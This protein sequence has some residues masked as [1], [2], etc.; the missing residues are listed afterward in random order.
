MY[1]HTECIGEFSVASQKNSRCFKKPTSDIRNR[2]YLLPGGLKNALGVLMNACIGRK[3]KIDVGRWKIGVLFDPRK[4]LDSLIHDPDKPEIPLPNARKN[5]TSLH[6]HLFCI[7]FQPSGS[8]YSPHSH[9]KQKNSTPLL[10]PEFTDKQSLPT[11]L[12]YLLICTTVL[13][14]T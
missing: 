11:P 5:H 7:H 3:K 8:V 6:S 10:I 9:R 1:I 14:P 12:Q 4:D 2:T 13:V